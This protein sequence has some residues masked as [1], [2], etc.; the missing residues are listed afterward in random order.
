MKRLLSLVVVL[1]L[2]IGGISFGTPPKANAADF[3]KE[4]KETLDALNAV[5]EKLGLGKLELDP[6]LT[7]AA[8]NHAEYL[9]TNKT[10]GHDEDPKKS[11]YTGADP[12]DRAEAVGYP[13]RAGVSEVGVCQDSCRDFSKNSMLS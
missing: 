7:E 5:R 13:N 12:I 3:P 10:T 2:V 11:G 8:Q 4:H 1:T 6:Y 9:T